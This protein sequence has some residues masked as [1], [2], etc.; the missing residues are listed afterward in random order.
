MPRDREDEFVTEDFERYKR[1][2]WDVEEAILKM[3]LT[4]ISVRN[5]SRRNR[6]TEQG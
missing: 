3:Y 6:R 1:M 2:T 4:G 5:D